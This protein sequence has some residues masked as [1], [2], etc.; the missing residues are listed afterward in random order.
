MI[1]HPQ[2]QGIQVMKKKSREARLLPLQIKVKVEF[3]MYGIG[4]ASMV[5]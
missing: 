3:I 4:I 5:I 1:N 2:V